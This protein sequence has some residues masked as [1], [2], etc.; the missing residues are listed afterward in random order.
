MMERLE[1]VEVT[2]QGSIFEEIEPI[3]VKKGRMKVRN[4]MKKLILTG[5]AAMAMLS[6]A[7]TPAM[8]IPSVDE[9]NE[10]LAEAVRAPDPATLKPGGAGGTALDPA[11]LTVG[12]GGTALDPATLTV[13]PR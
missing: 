13:G 7:A 3:K 12:A 4:S 1:E 8:A 2:E 9:I 11:T 10:T 5:A 6:F